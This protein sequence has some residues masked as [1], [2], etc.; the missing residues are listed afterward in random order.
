MH[1]VDR[2]VLLSA[3]VLSAVAACSSPA[4]VKTIDK[5]AQTD[6]APLV[7]RTRGLE[8]AT[9]VL[10]FSGRL[11]GSAPGPCSSWIDATIELPSD[12][13]DELRAHRGTGS[14][15]APEVVPD[16]ASSITTQDLVE[17]PE[18]AARVAAPGWSGRAWLSAQSP[19][20]VLSLTGQ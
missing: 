14:A 18:V 5:T 11:G 15:S 8:A 13:A 17:S 12:L 2:R 7:K 16:L 6:P 3:G 10:W 4:P 19:T 1:I 20:L 9:S